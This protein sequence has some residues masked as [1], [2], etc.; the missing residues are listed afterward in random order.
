M[1]VNYGHFT[2]KETFLHDIPSDENQNKPDG[3]D[4]KENVFIA[5]NER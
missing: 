2:P 5:P 1:R 4:A 3:D